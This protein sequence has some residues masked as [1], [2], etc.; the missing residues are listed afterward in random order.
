MEKLLQPA[1]DKLCKEITPSG[2]QEG[3]PSKHKY[4]SRK[5]HLKA[6]L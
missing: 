2:T 1:Y 5:L 4:A 3:K 6:T